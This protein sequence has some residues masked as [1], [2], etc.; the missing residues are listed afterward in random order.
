MFSRFFRASDL[1]EIVHCRQNEIYQQQNDDYYFLFD[2][3]KKKIIFMQREKRVVEIKFQ[4]E[5]GNK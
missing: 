2:F 4:I 5:E 1:D 3:V